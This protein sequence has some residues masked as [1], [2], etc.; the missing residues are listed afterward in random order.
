MN[1][2]GDVRIPKKDIDER[3]V[4]KISLMPEGQEKQLSR[5]EF[6]DLIVYL[7]SLR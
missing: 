2:A 6:L 1:L 5:Q 7:Q 4:Q 3:Q